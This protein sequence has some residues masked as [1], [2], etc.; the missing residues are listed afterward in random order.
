VENPPAL[1][2]LRS[3][4]PKAQEALFPKTPSAPQPKLRPQNPRAPRPSLR[5]KQRG[6][7]PRPKPAKLPKSPDS[8]LCRHLCR[9]L[10]YRPRPHRPRPRSRRASRERAAKRPRRRSGPS[11]SSP[12]AWSPL[13]TRRSPRYNAG[14][15]RIAGASDAAPALVAGGRFSR[16]ARQPAWAPSRHHRNGA[17]AA[18]AQRAAHR[19]PRAPPAPRSS[20]WRRA[21]LGPRTGGH[22]SPP[23]ESSPLSSPMP[24]IRIACAPAPAACK[25][26]PARRPAHKTPELNKCEQ[27]AAPAR[28]H[29]ERAGQ[30]VAS[31]G[32]FAG[33]GQVGNEW[34]V[35][36]PGECT[37]RATRARAGQGP[38][39]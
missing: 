4:N 17:D 32:D 27:R 7:S 31:P 37:E 11:T 29:L 18:A 9:P 39:V 12:T 33:K 35:P 30:C 15:R 10:Y 19:A 8:P 14:L 36:G 20:L 2:S 38:R 28:A 22:S 23:S 5:Q 13:R 1:I 6:G 25:P 24:I 26:E 3:P 21:A 34:Q 16:H